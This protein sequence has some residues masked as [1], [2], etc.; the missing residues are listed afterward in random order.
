VAVATRG[1]PT[2]GAP[3]DANAESVDEPTGYYVAGHDWPAIEN[4]LEIADVYS[5]LRGIT[6]DQVNATAD[7]LLQA[8]A[9][10][11]TAARGEGVAGEH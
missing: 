6:K 3:V 8:A 4:D 7:T 2:S 10:T 11:P 5:A 9:E 1:R